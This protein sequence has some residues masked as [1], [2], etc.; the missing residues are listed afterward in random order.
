MDFK[1]IAD[2]WVDQQV[3]LELKRLEAEASAFLAMGYSIEELVLVRFPDFSL[4]VQP[5]R[6]RSGPCARRT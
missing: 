6:K 1:S 2:Q 4:Q 5:V 3:R